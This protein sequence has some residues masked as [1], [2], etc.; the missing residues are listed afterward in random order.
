VRL[1]LHG[2]F[3]V[4]PLAFF[5][6]IFNL[7][8][9]TGIVLFAIVAGM[10]LY[11][12]PVDNVIPSYKKY[13]ITGLNSHLM[14]TVGLENFP[15]IRSMYDIF[16][17]EKLSPVIRYRIHWLVSLYYFYSRTFLVSLAQGS[18]FSITL[19][20]SISPHPSFGPD[21]LPGVSNSDLLTRSV[22]LLVVSF[23]IALV[24][25]RQSGKGIREVANLEKALVDYHKDQIQEI[26][27]I[28][29]HLTPG[30]TPG[31]RDKS[32]LSNL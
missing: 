27:R 31:T 10:I 21:I 12:V 6:E 29:G 4:Y 2:I 25:F 7:I 22:I 26:A 1:F 19:L 8:T 17:Y 11:A 32:S 18:L 15:D 14:N 5:P 9:P 20:L 30:G 16:F 28:S 3:T 23:G 13:Y 24:A